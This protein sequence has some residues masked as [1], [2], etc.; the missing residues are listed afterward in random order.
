MKKP[1][2]TAEKEHMELVRSLPCIICAEDWFDET[3][4]M[5]LTLV[6][7]IGK[8]YSEFDHMIDGYRL[9]HMF[10]IPLCKPHHKGKKGYGPKE[11][12]WDSSKPN[13]WRLLE[14]V[15]AVL[16]KPV[17]KYNPKGRNNFAN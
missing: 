16:G 4:A 8:T 12:H 13:Q 15:Y 11:Y 7:H 10:G 6:S 3:I 17:P 9:G 1:A 2:T 5:D 14:K